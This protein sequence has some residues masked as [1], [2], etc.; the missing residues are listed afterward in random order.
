MTAITFSESAIRDTVFLY[1][2]LQPFIT[3]SISGHDW[4]SVASLWED[5]SLLLCCLM[6]RRWQFGVLGP[7]GA[8]RNSQH[9]IQLPPKQPVILISF[10]HDT[11]VCAVTLNVWFELPVWFEDLP[12]WAFT[13][14]ICRCLYCM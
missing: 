14:T 7:S 8:W 13:N 12:D 1:A 6:R 4:C 5:A 10:A 3:V 9:V 2:F 11:F